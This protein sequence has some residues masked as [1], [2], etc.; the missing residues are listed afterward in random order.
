MCLYSRFLY[1]RKTLK[2]NNSVNIVTKL[3]ESTGML[4]GGHARIAPVVL[5]AEVYDAVGQKIK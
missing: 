1:A 3:P 2:L 5:K 4:S